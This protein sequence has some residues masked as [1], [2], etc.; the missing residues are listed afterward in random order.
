MLK[1]LEIGTE[2][3]FNNIL[4]RVVE[5]A[6]WEDGC[7]RCYFSRRGICCKDQVAD[8]VVGSCIAEVR[9]DSRNIYFKRVRKRG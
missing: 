9:S 6:S 4:L 3:V 8:W 1:T 7:P 2:V 5:G